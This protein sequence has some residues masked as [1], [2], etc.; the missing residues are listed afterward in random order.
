MDG[1]SVHNA[2]VATGVPVRQYTE[3]VDTLTISLATCPGLTSTI[4]KPIR[5]RSSTE[6][7][8][9]LA[10]DYVSALAARAVLVTLREPF[11]F[12][13]MTHHEIDDEAADFAVQQARTVVCEVGSSQ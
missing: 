6:P 2:A 3:S 8:G 10:Q 5:S 7:S 13:M 11:V 1:A 12:K 9:R 4:P